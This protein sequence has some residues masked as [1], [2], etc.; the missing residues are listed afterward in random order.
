MSTNNKNQQRPSYN[1]ST[2][3]YIRSI[4][5][6][7][8]LSIETERMV[9]D[10]IRNGI[11]DSRYRL[12]EGCLRFVIRVASRYSHLNVPFQDLI[13][14]GNIGLIKA[15]DKF[16][17]DKE[18]RFITIAYHHIVGEILASI[19]INSSL[20]RIPKY[21]TQKRKKDEK[22]LNSNLFDKDSAMD[23]A[24]AIELKYLITWKGYFT[25]YRNILDD[26]SFMALDGTN[27]F[28]LINQENKEKELKRQLT[29]ALSVLPEIERKVIVLYFG[30]NSEYKNAT[31]QII[32]DQMGMSKEGVRV[33]KLRALKK[34]NEF[35]KNI[36]L[37]DYMGE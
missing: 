1:S 8:I 19:H 34:L 5:K 13:N 32:S 25:K 7:N 16:D 6:F 24:S 33:I 37:E 18:V 17:P 9:S 4:S 30:L 23:N 28:S 35:L 2:E 36:D 10:D 11:N 22:A 3:S 27:E 26:S 31:F 21:V 29:A 20:V 12:I 15:A 14:D